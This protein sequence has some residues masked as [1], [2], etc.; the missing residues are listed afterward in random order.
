MCCFSLSFS[1]LCLLIFF[2]RSDNILNELVSYNVPV[3]KAVYHNVIDIFKYLDS[4]EIFLLIL[5]HFA[6]C[7][8]S[9]GSVIKSVKSSVFATESK[10]GDMDFDLIEEVSADD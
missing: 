2:I 6:A 7:A 4:A 1:F 5:S 3:G 9:L 8:L 10:E